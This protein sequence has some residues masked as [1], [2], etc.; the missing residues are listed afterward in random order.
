MG[1]INKIGGIAICLIGIAVWYVDYMVFSA[2]CAIGTYVASLIGATGAATLGVLI[3]EWF[4]S[5]GL[6]A[7]LFVIGVLIEIYGMQIIIEG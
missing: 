3:I 4:L 7:T 6:M 2:V 5:I 1:I